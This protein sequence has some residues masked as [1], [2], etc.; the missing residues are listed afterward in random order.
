M[1]CSEVDPSHHLY[2]NRKE[3]LEP[4]DEIQ[5]RNLKKDADKEF[6]MTVTQTFSGSFINQVQVPQY[7]MPGNFGVRTCETMPTNSRTVFID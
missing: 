2:P 4:K 7:D 5:L 3:R 1:R 6:A